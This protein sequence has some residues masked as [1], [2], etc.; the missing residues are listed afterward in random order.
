MSDIGF[1]ALLST[2]PNSLCELKLEDNQISEKSLPVLL[3]FFKRQLNLKQISLRKNAISSNNSIGVNVPDL[4][5]Q[6][7]KV[8][9]K[10]HCIFTLDINEWINNKMEEL[11]DGNINLISTELRGHHILQLYNGMKKTPD[12]DWSM[13]LS[14][15]E[16]ISPIGYRQLGDI[17]SSTLHIVEL[18]L[19]GNNMDEEERKCLLNG[20][21]NNKTLSKFQIW[22]KLNNQDMEYIGRFIQNNMA[23]KELNLY[24]CYMG[25]DDVVPLFKDLPGSHL[26][27]L[28]LSNN[29][30]GDRTCAS[31]LSSIPSTLRELSFNDNKI[32]QA[33]LE[34][35]VT[36]LTT[37]QT[38]KILNIKYASIFENNDSDEHENIY[39]QQINE[40]AKQNGICEL[41]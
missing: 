34:T 2:L 18:D 28:C 10:K 3:T 17:L 15:N 21:Q 20:L 12:R 11:T 32:T 38:L 33:S 31:L 29:S 23:L 19:R 24:W 30:L 26:E 13:D 8:T 7:L 9:D 6:I 39:W 14:C 41:I 36:F 25:D 1:Q 37:N 40:A 4:V 22:T 16:R 27:I 5:E 35:I